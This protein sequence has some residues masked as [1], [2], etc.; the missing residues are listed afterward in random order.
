MRLTSFLL[1]ARLG[2]LG[3]GCSATTEIDEEVDCRDVCNRYQSCYDSSYDTAA[4]RDR[5]GALVDA[6]GGDPRAANECDTCMDDRSC[7]SA[8]FN[9]AQ[10]C[11]G[12]LP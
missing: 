7:F 1:I 2:S 12:I 10:P 5:C 9:C 8:V 4:C 11:E 3:A 6:V